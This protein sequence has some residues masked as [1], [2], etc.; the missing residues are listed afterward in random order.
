MTDL[1]SS[2]SDWWASKQQCI[3]EGLDDARLMKYW[4]A[5]LKAPVQ[6]P[7]LYKLSNSTRYN[8]RPWEVEARVSEIKDIL[9]CIEKST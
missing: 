5:M 6:S 9:G 3:Q 4:P 1:I 2:V 8:P 7:D